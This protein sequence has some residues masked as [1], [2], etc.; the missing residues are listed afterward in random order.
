MRVTIGVLV[1]EEPVESFV[2]GEAS[3]NTGAQSRREAG[4][5]EAECAAL[6]APYDAT[7]VITTTIPVEQTTSNRNGLFMSWLPDFDFLRNEEDQLESP[8]PVHGMAFQGDGLD[9]VPLIAAADL[10]ELDPQFNWVI[11]PSG[12]I[13][14]TY[15]YTPEGNAAYN[16]WLA[17]EYSE[18]A[19]VACS[20]KI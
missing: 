10:P 9:G 4:Y 2:N 11:T 7:S 1:P 19:L 8:V 20:V 17:S 18:A 3:L 14:D 16:R 15:D 12:T 6:I 13:T 5:V